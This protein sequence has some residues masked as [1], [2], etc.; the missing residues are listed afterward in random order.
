MD[1]AA[2]LNPEQLAPV[3]D[4]DG[5]VLVLAGAGSGKTRVLT[6]RIAY[7]IERKGVRPS[8][9]LAITFTNKAAGEMKERVL[10]LTGQSGVWISTFHSLCARILRA[11]IDKLGEFRSNFTIYDDS[12]TNR[13]LSRIF[14]SMDVEDTK[15]WKKIVRWHIS[16]A[17]N[18]ALDAQAYAPRI[19]DQ[20][21][22]EL[23][24]SVHRAYEQELRQ[25]NALDFDDLL[26]QTILLFSKRKDVLERYQDMFRYLHIDEFQ[27]TNKIQY[28]LVRL[29]AHKHGN[30]FAVGDDDQSIYGWRGADV[31]NIRNFTKQFAGC[32]IYKL[33]Q[34]Y[35]STGNILNLAN[36]IIAHNSERMGKTLWTSSDGGV[37]VVYRTNYD[38]RGEA[39]FVLEQIHALIEHNG[40][41]YGDFA[42]LTRVNSITRPF[43]EK[44]ALYNYPYRV[45]GGNKFFE[46]KEVK[47]FLAYLKFVA[48][49]QDNESVMRVINVPKRG[50][51]DT[52]VSQLAAACISNGVGLLEGMLAPDRLGVSSQL[53]A[54]AA[55]FG[56]V[57]YQLIANK[58]LPLVEYI[59]YALRTIDFAQMYDIDNAEDKERL[60]NI[61]D[62]VASV[63]EYCKDNEDATL[64]E[65]LQS[66]SLISDTDSQPDD[67]CI[68]LATVHGVKGLEFRCGFIVGLE[69]GIFPAIRKDAGESEMQE[70]RRI[71]YVAVT[72]ARERLY[73][74]NAQSRFRFGKREN[75]QVSRF[76]V[77][78]EVVTKRLPAQSDDDAPKRS[79]FDFASVARMRQPAFAKPS[80]AVTQISSKDISQFK[81]GMTV[82]HARFGQGK[83]IDITG[84]N[85]K[86]DFP[87][88]GVKTFN[89]RL[90]PV[91]TVEP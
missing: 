68:T 65:Y 67:D 53:A 58:H 11:D 35:R 73:L 50:I 13:V 3:I 22:H 5:A 4:T 41:D 37:K 43:E 28:L 52:A 81:I 85:A 8:Q 29:L 90:A 57:A 76:L 1:Y 7:L 74:S 72:R 69:E 91:R 60:A 31:S 2:L 86:I 34:N 88:L 79:G 6:H 89:M 25:N 71:M 63:K 80:A 56:A 77:E 87:V 49:P 12:D 45:I 70:E 32:R 42:I 27:D 55:R 44:L 10:K 66:V 14:K 54:K 47:D 78:G 24:S 64:Q 20:P 23:I 9:I 61:D 82:E 21:N 51:G 19:S 62:F 59:D 46:R 15:E 17:K 30:V 48:N 16:N 83:I 18:M 39:E 40:Y 33:E 75:C 84:E 38:E 26:W 36:K